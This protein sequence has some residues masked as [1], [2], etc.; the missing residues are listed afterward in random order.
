MNAMVGYHWPG[1][2]RELQNIIERAVIVSTGPMLKV[3]LG[4]LKARV[5]SGRDS[6]RAGESGD[7]GKMRDVLQQT[8]HNQILTALKQS[9]WVVAGPKG[10]AA[11]LGT[12]RSTLQVHIQRLGIRIS[13]TGN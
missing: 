5:P 3:P 8:E 4:D 13:R 6:N 12:N 10:A 9:N 1:N 11:L 2:I 7:T